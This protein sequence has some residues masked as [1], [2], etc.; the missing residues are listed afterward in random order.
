MAEE[1]AKSEQLD[2]IDVQPENAA[3][4]AK[5]AGQY[6]EVVARRIKLAEKEVDL[7]QKILRL[8]DDGN[9]QRLDKG[10]RKLKV[11]HFMIETEPKEESV[12]VR[13]V[14]G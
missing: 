11:G 13:E 4:I 3:E 6:R 2:L 14:D 8:F 9:V 12:K 5:Y 1:V 10:K 7:K